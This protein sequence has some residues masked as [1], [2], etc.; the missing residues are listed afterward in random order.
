MT[1]TEE[2]MALIEPVE[3]EGPAR[4]WSER[5]TERRRRPRARDSA[6]RGVKLAIS[7]AHEGL[8][9]AITRVLCA[10]WQRCRVPVLRNALAHAAWTGRRVVSAFMAVLLHKSAEGRSFPFSGQGLSF[11]FSDRDAARGDAVE[12]GDTD[13]ETGD[14]TVEAPCGQALPQQL[15][16]VHLGLCAASRVIPFGAALEPA[17]G[18]PLTIVAGSFGRSDEARRASVR[19]TAPPV[20]GV[21]GLA[22]LRG[23]M[24]PAAPRAAM[25]SWHLRVSKAP[26]T[27]TVAIS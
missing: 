13:L 15:D 11:D 12:H 7:D 10:T 2:K 5:R 23:G 22:F 9:A 27:V 1:L 17:A 18:W 8:K 24:I 3:S 20:S 16:A 19:A 26:S 14:L 25:A 6:L 21:Q 4:H